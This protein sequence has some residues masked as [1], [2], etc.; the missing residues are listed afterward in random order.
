MIFNYLFY[1]HKQQQQQRKN[2]QTKEY[3]EHIERGNLLPNI[4]LLRNGS[5][6]ENFSINSAY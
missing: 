1:H 2:Q 4:D 6:D 3:S 5:F